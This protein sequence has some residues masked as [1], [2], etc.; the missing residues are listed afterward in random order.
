MQTAFCLCGKRSP[1]QAGDGLRQ[2]RLLIGR[3]AGDAAKDATAAIAQ[4]P[5]AGDR[6]EPP[7]QIAPGLSGLGR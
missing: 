6:I 1:F 3:P 5:L 2:R 7:R 4:E